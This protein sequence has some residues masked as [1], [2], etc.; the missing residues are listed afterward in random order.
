LTLSSDGIAWLEEGSQTD[1]TDGNQLVKSVFFY[2]N[3]NGEYL[4]AAITLSFNVTN[5][6]PIIVFAE[7]QGS[8]DTEGQGG[9]A[10]FG[11]PPMLNLDLPAGA[12]VTTAS[13][14]ENFTTPTVPEPSTW[15]MMLI[16]FAGL[17]FAGYRRARRLSA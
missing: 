5:G 3:T 16:G 6:A 11:D 13:V 4:P 8:G 1:F 9:V 10:D 2:S 17:G 12:S 15:A 14:F 7:L